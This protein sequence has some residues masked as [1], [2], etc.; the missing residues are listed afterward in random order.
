MTNIVQYYVVAKCVYCL[1]AFDEV[2]GFA[3]RIFLQMR[4][5]L[6]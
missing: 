2:G 5:G 3:V 1:L 4:S 6:L